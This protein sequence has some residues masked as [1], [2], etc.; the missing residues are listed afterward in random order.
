MKKNLFFLAILCWMIPIYSSAQS[1]DATKTGTDLPQNVSTDSQVFNDF[2]TKN[3]PADCDGGMGLLKN[4]Y[5]SL[6]DVKNDNVYLF[7]ISGVSDVYR[8]KI[9]NPD[10]N[11]YPDETAN[12]RKKLYT[13]NNKIYCEIEAE[14]EGLAGSV[15]SKTFFLEKNKTTN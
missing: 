2:K 7:E 11:L 10:F 13:I 14:N 5:Y 15:M 8:N 3:A 12:Y 9:L 6:I 1:N 4:G